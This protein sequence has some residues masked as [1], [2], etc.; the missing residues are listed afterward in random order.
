MKAVGAPSGQYFQGDR[1]DLLSW[2]GG[3]HAR[4]LE[5]GCGR[6]GNAPWLR[7]HGADRLVGI[8]IDAP[9]ANAARGMFDVVL[10]ED[11]ET[12]L[13]K[14]DESFDLVV[15]ADVLEHLVD[16]WGTLRRLRSVTAPGGTLIM[17]IPNIR[18][19]RALW[20]IG[21]G[22]GF[23]YQPEGIFDVTHLR[24]FTRSTIKAMVQDEGWT[25]A[26][27]GSSPVR[28]G[29][30][31]RRALSVATFG[32]SDEWLTY[33]WYVSAHPRPDSHLTDSGLR[34]G[35]VTRQMTGSAS[36]PGSPP[37]GR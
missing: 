5:I 13:D 34:T 20:K 3:H 12:A 30:R 1:R 31:L 4:V 18:F 27:M 16:P 26:R 19:Y 2:L 14:L 21:F 17:S 28:R 35:N 32:R 9:A 24:F 8:E 29:R 11:V 22:E 36:C 10:A 7:E 15:C 25:L 37:P 6:G 23:R 33:Q